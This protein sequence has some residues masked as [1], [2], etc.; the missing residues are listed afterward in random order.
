MDSENKKRLQTPSWLL[1]AE[2][3]Y[4]FI[5]AVVAQEITVFNGHPAD[6]APSAIAG[7]TRKLE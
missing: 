4:G 6:T 1:L 2:K 3:E 5:P 7:I